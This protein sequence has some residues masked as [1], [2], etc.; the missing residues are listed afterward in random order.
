MATMDIFNDNAF[1]MVS[2][3]QALEKM[4]FQPTLLGSLNIFE[5]A[6]VRTELV[7]IEKREDKLAVI[8]TSN[9]GAP[10]DR[11]DNEKRDIRDFRTNRIAKGDRIT[12]SEIQN[13]RAFGSETE[14]M[15][16]QAEVIRR[17]QTILTD[18]QVTFENMRLGAIQGIVLDADGTSLRNWYTEWGISQA[19]EIDFELDDSATDV[20]KKCNVVVRAMMKASKGAWIPGRTAVHALCGDTFYDNL[21]GH[22]SVKDTYLNWAAATDLRQGN[23]Y[24]AFTFGGITFHNYRGADDFTAQGQAGTKGLGIDAEKAKFFPVGAPGVFKHAMSPGESFEYVN[25]PGSPV[26]GMIVP[27]QQRN[28]WVDVEAYSYPLMICTRPEMLQRAKDH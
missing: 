21:T 5:P 11:S 10:I 7:S 4:P 26:Y 24:E 25:T 2:L 20:R 16:V 15:Q 6:P 28:M 27:D 12:A 22:K 1:S 14:L 17:Y 23:A 13:I 9:R 8:Q 19:N 3:T 18:V